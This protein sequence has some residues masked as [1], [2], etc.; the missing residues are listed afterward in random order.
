M[1][2]IKN[3]NDVNDKHIQNIHIHFKEEDILRHECNHIG[4]RKDDNLATFIFIC[5]VDYPYAK[6]AQKRPYFTWTL[7]HDHVPQNLRASPRY[8]LARFRARAAPKK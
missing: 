7:C 5:R 8:R 4:C 6:E 1:T 3:I 2:A